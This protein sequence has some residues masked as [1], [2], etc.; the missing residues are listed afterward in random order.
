M[1]TDIVADV[2]MVSPTIIPSNIS[3][4]NDGSESYKDWEKINV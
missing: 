3:N 2:E 4:Q 1:K